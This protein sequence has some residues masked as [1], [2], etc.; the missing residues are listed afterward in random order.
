[1][2]EIEIKDTGIGIKPEDQTKLF[3]LFGFLDT[4]K[5]L[6]TKG[7]GLGLHICK[8][9]AQQF[10][11]E[12]TCKSEWQVGSSFIFLF[13][14]DDIPTQIAKVQR[15]KNPSK[16]QYPKINCRELNVEQVD[17]LLES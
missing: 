9:I 2:I 17:L 12:I 14:L 16:F 4:T 13:D 3:K 10:G 5:E 1:M 15:I 6:N 11:G 8:L 7:I